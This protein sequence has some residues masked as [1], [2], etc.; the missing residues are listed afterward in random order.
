M[1]AKT[2]KK[3]GR[4]LKGDKPTTNAERINTFRQKLDDKGLALIQ[5][6][7]T[8]AQR[9]ILPLYAKAEGYKSVSSF[10]SALLAEKLAELKPDIHERIDRAHTAKLIGMDKQYILE[11][12]QGE[13][14]TLLEEDGKGGR[15]L[16]Q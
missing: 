1:N 12:L 8:K 6:A 15:K 4:P 16:K 2:K 3:A 5:V 9:E 10:L 13:R 7:V 11:V 14:K